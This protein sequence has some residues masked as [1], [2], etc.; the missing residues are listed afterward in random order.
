MEEKIVRVIKENISRPVSLDKESSL[1]ANGIDSIEFITIV[2]ALEE[3][4][5]IKFGD[6]QLVY[7]N[8]KTLGQLLST[9]QQVIE[10][11]NN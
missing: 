9:V 10:E 7:S 6:M 2:I 4:F 8:Y 3:E 1:A 5:D 11:K